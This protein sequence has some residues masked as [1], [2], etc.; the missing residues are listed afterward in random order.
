MWFLYHKN[1]PLKPDIRVIISA[2]C[3][4]IGKVAIPD[5]ILKKPT[6][7]S[8]DEFEE[9]KSHPTIGADLLA[10]VPRVEK[11]IDGIKHHHERWDGTGY[12]DG[13]RGE[14]IPSYDN[15]QEVE[16]RFLG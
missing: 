2:L 4:D 5:M 11:F 9:M 16:F 3:H 7:L 12:P 10:N 14:N 13:L 1:H 15:L 6:R 8:V